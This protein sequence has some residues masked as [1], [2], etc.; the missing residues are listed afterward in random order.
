[1][2]THQGKLNIR[3]KHACKRY[4]TEEGLKKGHNK[5]GSM[6]EEDNQLYR[7]PQMTGQAR[8]DDE[9]T[10]GSESSPHLPG[11]V[12]TPVPRVIGTCGCGCDACDFWL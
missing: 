9:G 6:D 2:W 10:Q 12:E 8:D 4:T 3:W 1:M 7:R 11:Y 5:Q